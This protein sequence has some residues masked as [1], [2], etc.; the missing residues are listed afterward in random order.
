MKPYIITMP[1]PITALGGLHIWIYTNIIKDYFYEEPDAW[2][3]YT[4]RSIAKD[5]GMDTPKGVKMVT[6][7]LM[8]LCDL[9]FVPCNRD[10]NLYTM[11]P[12]NVLPDDVLFTNIPYWCM[13]R[14]LKY[15]GKKNYQ[16]L[17]FYLIVAGTIDFRTNVGWYS[18]AKIAE[19]AKC[20]EGTVSRRFTLLEEMGV[21]NVRR[22]KN[23]E[24]SNRY[25]IPYY[26]RIEYIPPIDPK[27]EAAA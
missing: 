12:N 14:V 20:C 13:S 9:D 2:R 6:A 22:S 19:L 26:D 4:A 18:Q 17:Q 11:C 27:F 25:S 16:L 10:G 23:M 15:G 1:K 3:S 5:I 21:I 24:T 7:V 8:D